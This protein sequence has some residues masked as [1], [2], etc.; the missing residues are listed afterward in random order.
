MGPLRPLKN[1]KEMTDMSYGIK[2]LGSK[3][4]IKEVAS[5][6]L[7]LAVIVYTKA[8]VNVYVQAFG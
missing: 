5:E 6:V 8:R 7:L 3:V 2:P 1:K 4:V